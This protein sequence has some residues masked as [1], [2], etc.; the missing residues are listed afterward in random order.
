M[1]LSF[2]VFSFFICCTLFAQEQTFH[3]LDKS[4]KKPISFATVK[5]LHSTRGVIAG[6]KGDFN[7]LILPNDTII[8]SSIGYH[9]LR[10]VGSEVGNEILLSP[11]VSN[12]ASVTIRNRKP[13]K[14][15]HLGFDT[16]TL[17]Y[18]GTWGPSSGKPEFAQEFFLPIDEKEYKMNKIFIPVDKQG[19]FSQL[20]LHVYEKDSSTG[21]PGEPI[22][23]KLVAVNRKNVKKEI[24][25]IDLSLDS[26]YLSDMDSFFIG[27]SWA[28]SDDKKCI[29]GLKMFYNMTNTYSRLLGR[30]TY[31]WFP[32]GTQKTSKGE[33][34]F[35]GVAWKVEL[36][37]YH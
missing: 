35:A 7:L 15:F 3:I 16:D 34:S 9:T 33:H 13:E 14:V 22:F 30:N 1:K 28:P 8:V 6:E 27:I 12:L 23:Q 21:M 36:E 4:N 32:F 20:I 25:T 17:N 37:Q 2:I 19:C 18:W 29:L 10:M 5:V 31:D 26:L 24:L 11:K